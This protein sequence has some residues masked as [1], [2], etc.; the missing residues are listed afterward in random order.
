M[1]IFPEMA[2]AMRDDDVARYVACL[3][4]DF[5]YIR[6]KSKDSLNR[7]QMSA[8]LGRVWGGGNRTIDD[9]RCIY[10]NDDILVIHTCLTFKNGSREAAMIVSLKNGGKVIRT[11]TGVSDL[12]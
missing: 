12:T 6:H 3:H 4:E 5:Q 7:D 10:E 11:E 8:L 1:N 9:L 2:A